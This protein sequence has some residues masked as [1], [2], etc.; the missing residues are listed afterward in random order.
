[1]QPVGRVEELHLA[2]DTEVLGKER[3]AAGAVAAHLALGAVGVVVAHRAVELGAAP[4]R[5]QP[6]GP[7]AEVAVA[8]PRNTRGV[9]REA[10]LTVVEQDEVVARTL[11]FGK[12][13]Q[14]VQQCYILTKIIKLLKVLLLL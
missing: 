5:H 14:H 3:E 8:E 4:Q 13:E 10:L 12:L 7:D 1:M 2:A 9:G 6:V 11:V